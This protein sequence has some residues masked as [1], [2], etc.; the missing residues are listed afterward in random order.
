MKYGGRQIISP[1][2]LTAD[3]SSD[4]EVSRGRGRFLRD[5]GYDKTAYDQHQDNRCYFHGL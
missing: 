2:D 3:L 4:F 5:R 1:V